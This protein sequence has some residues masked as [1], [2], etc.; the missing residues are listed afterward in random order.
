MSV[1]KTDAAQLVKDIRR[2]KVS[3]HCIAERCGSGLAGQAYGF[4]GGLESI[5][6]DFLRKQQCPDAAAALVRAMNDEPTMA[7]IDERNAS[8]AAMGAARRAA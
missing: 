6:Q 7:E 1:T 8:I 3:G 4:L 5:L 2:A